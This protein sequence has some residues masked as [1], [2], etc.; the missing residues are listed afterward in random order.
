FY[1]LLRFSGGGSQRLAWE[2]T[3]SLNGEPAIPTMSADEIADLGGAPFTV[4]SRGGTH[5]TQWRVVAVNFSAGGPMLDGVAFIALPLT[6]VHQ[7]SGILARTLLAAGAAII[8][9]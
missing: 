7:A 1:V 8:L 9:L 4:A 5:P 2:P 6:S 3:I